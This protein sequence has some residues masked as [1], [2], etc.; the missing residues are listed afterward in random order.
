MIILPQTFRNGT[1]FLG[2]VK[3]PKSILLP[4]IVKTLTNDTELITALNRLGHGI[5]Y[6]TLM[7]IQTENAYMIVDQQI[8]SG[9][10]LPINCLK[11]VFSIYVADNIDR[12]EE[13]LSGIANFNLFRKIFS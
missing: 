4:S 5:S 3:T 7:E 11:E 13:T 2:R 1:L 10:V 12:K 8:Q 9:C 6:T